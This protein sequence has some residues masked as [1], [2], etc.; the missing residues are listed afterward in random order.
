MPEMVIRP[1]YRSH[2][3]L[4]AV[5]ESPDLRRR[6]CAGLCFIVRTPVWFRAVIGLWS[7]WFVAVLIEP[8]ITHVCAMHG[9]TSSAR[10]THAHGTADD[11]AEHSADAAPSGGVCHNCLDSCCASHAV[12]PGRATLRSGPI[13]IGGT[14]GA[15]AV[16]WDGAVRAPH[17][18]PFANGP[19]RARA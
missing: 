19:P 11:G 1:P 9:P 17:S 4:S 10:T 6:V 7:F 15:W 2:G 16:E 3:L 13:A 18:L 14:G 5:S 8:G 12:V